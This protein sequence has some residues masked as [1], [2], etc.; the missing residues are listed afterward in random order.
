MIDFSKIE[1]EKIPNMRGGEGVAR[2]KRYADDL[3]K[4]MQI[5]LEKG[6]SIGLHRHESDLEVI[7]AISGEA[8]CTLDGKDE[9]IRAGQCHYCPRGSAHMEKN[10]SDEPFVMLAVVPKIS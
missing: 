2:V 4:V 8:V 1:E 10:I 3:V 9:Y 5:T 7:Y 6:C